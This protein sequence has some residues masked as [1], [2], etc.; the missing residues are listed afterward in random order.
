M[1]WIMNGGSAAIESYGGEIDKEHL[2]WFAQLPY[3]IEHENFVMSHSNYAAGIR[4]HDAKTYTIWNRD[5]D[6][7][8]NDGTINIF[9]HTPVEHP[10]I[11]ESFIMLDTGCVFGKILSA[12]DTETGIIYQ[13]DNIESAQP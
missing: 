3:K 8:F 10:E 12:Y 13:Q 1:N 6:V 4:A 2:D 11:R 7:F 5:F 9:G